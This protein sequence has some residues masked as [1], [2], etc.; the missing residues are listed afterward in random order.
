MPGSLWVHDSKYYEK[1]QTPTFYCS[2]YK[3]ASKKTLKFFIKLILVILVIVFLVG[4]IR[5]FVKWYSF[6]ERHSKVNSI[7][8][9]KEFLDQ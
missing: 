6:E 5:F 8:E 3:I 9:M 7:G 1:D 4:P 2:N